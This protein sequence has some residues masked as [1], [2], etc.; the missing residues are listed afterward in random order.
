MTPVTT[1]DNG[2]LYQ[3]FVPNNGGNTTQFFYVTHVW[4]T[5]YEWGYA[6]GTMLNQTVRDFI[7]QAWD[8]FD[9]EIGQY[10]PFLPPW[11]GDMI[12]DVGLDVA[13]DW[14]AKVSEP[15]T[16]PYI[17]DE[18][19][20]LADAS[21]VSYEKILRIH[22]LPG[23]TKGRCSM[24]GAWG[25]AIPG[26]QGN[27]LQ[28]RALDWDMDGPFRDYAAIT[29]YHPLNDTFGHPFAN[30]G[31]PGFIGSLTGMSATQLGISEIGV[32]Y[33]DDT[34][35]NETQA[36]I[37]FIFLLRDVLQY[38]YTIDDS[39]S[40]MAVAHRTCRLILGV[41]DGKLGEFRGF[42][43]SETVLNVF[44]DLN[45]MPI[46]EWHPRI[47][48]IVYW[49]MDWDCPSYNQVLN[50]ELYAYYGN[51]TAYN[52]LH[53]ISAIEQSGDN[54]IAYYD[55]Q[56]MLAYV[57]FAAPH[58]VGGPIEAYARQYTVIDVASLFEEQ[59][60]SGPYPKTFLT[61]Q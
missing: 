15:Y 54:H 18:L 39:I 22:M 59:P 20:G 53:Y 9:Q 5:P 52:G 50:E 30:I 32:G 36:G 38:D 51:I 11:L 42:Q 57:A 61:K 4:G 13:L 8:Y 55:L 29:V 35:G 60:P 43:Y 49:G 7:D 48:D 2:K 21:Q 31:F 24:L 40:R 19:H 56:Q 34:W 6:Q 14:V 33:P 1:T 37:P 44:D 3:V 17:Y 16:S 41:G 10:I 58:N 46:A 25:A 28:L 12:A 27:I 26:T 47:N 45:Q 23:L